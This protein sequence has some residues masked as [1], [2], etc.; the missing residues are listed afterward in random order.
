M[1]GY[2]C[3]LARTYY[4]IEFITSYLNWAENEDDMNNGMKLIKEY[5]FKIK[6]PE[7][8]YSKGEFFFNKETQTIYKGIGSIKFLNSQVGDELFALKDVIYSTFLDL[9]IDIKT[10]VSCDSRQLDL[11]VKI[12]FFKEFGGIKTLLYIIDLYDKFYGKQSLSKEKLD[13]LNLSLDQVKKYGRET[14]KKIMEFNSISLIKDL[15]VN[16]KDED[17]TVIELIKMQKEILGYID[18][19]DETL[20]KNICLVNTLDAQYNTKKANL[21]CL[22]NGKILEFKISK[23]LFDL[24][25]FEEGDIIHINPVKLPKPIII[26]EKPNG[27]P[28]WGKNFSIME[29]NLNNY[30]IVKEL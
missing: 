10:K 24:K 21:Y 17:F 12:D 6:S 4:P 11:L 16:I 29:W 3:S 25:P 27:K 19:K 26:G 28:L 5:G 14:P 8:R 13:E 15:I 7:F 9:L 18:Y 23:K 30:N 1:N 2:L 20:D 22:N